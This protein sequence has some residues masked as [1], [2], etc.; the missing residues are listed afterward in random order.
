[1]DFKTNPATKKNYTEHTVLC[2]TECNQRWSRQVLGEHIEGGWMVYSMSDKSVETL[3]TKIDSRASWKHPPSPPPP[4]Q[5]WFFY[6]FDCTENSAHTT[7]N[8]GVEGIRE[9]TLDANSVK[10]VLKY[11]K[12]SFLKFLKYFCRSLAHLFL[13]HRTCYTLYDKTLSLRMNSD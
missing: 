2:S 12:A 8:W 9:L 5:C 10:Q 4:K 11:R 13:Y 1:M 6:F 7:L 3:G